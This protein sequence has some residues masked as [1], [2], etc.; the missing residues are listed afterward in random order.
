M[1]HIKFTCHPDLLGVKGIRPIPSKLDI[2]D[3]Y[4][5]LNKQ[6]NEDPRNQSIKSCIPVLDSIT[7]GYLLPLPQDLII[8]HNV[9]VEKKKQYMEF[10]GFGHNI[11]S[12]SN[13]ILAEYN[14]NENAAEHPPGQVGGKDSF[15]GKKNKGMGI[16]KILNPWKIETPSGYSCLFIPPMHREMDYFQILPG[17]VDTDTFNLKINFP[18]IINTD[19]Y[20]KI[21]TVLRQGTPYVQV[22]PFKRDNWKMQI[23][24][25][26]NSLVKTVLHNLSVNDTY[27]RFSWNKKSYR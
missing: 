4:K 21:D 3:W 23:G 19:K 24:E 26:K 1:K 11:S 12:D 18:F 20:E 5:K 27:K 15:L 7:N 22:I 16:P 2:P 6:M 25:Q 9:W 13:P 17:I 8:Q 10:V 14:L